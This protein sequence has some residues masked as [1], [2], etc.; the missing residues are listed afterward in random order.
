[1]QNHINIANYITVHPRVCHGKPCFKGTR[2][3]VYLVLELLEAG[4]PQEE[5]IRRYYPQ[6]THKHIEAA[7]H[8]AGELFKTREYAF[9]GAL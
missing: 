1:M 3:M 8:Y 4:I 6:L 5:I 9:Q 7:L 2:I